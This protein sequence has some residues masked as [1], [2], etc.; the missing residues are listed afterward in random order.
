MSTDD[1]TAR[2]DECETPLTH[3]PLSALTG[4][5]LCP[6]CRYQAGQDRLMAALRG[7]V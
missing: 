6:T 7:D 3:A 1:L 4:H 2:C 5:R